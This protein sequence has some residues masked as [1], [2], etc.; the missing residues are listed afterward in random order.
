MIMLSHL[1]KKKI[2]IGRSMATIVISS[3]KAFLVLVRHKTSYKTPA[4]LGNKVK[5]LK[6]N[7]IC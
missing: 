2:N 1:I 4:A 5:T 6:C 7:S 3:Y